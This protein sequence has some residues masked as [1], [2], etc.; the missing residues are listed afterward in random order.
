MAAV[1]WRSFGH[2]DLTSHAERYRRVHERWLTRALA[3]ARPI[4]R[5]PVRRVDRGGFDRLRDRPG[6]QDLAERWWAL[7]MATV[8]AED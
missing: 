8:D 1:F 3:S 7:A 4:P 2:G 6:G 5:I